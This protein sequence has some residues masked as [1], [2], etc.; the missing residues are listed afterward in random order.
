MKIGWNSLVFVFFIQKRISVKNL[1]RGQ[2]SNTN[3]WFR[4]KSRTKNCYSYDL[5]LRAHRH[6]HILGLQKL[7]TKDFTFITEADTWWLAASRNN[8]LLF[9]L[10]EEVVYC[11]NSTEKDISSVGEIGTSLTWEYQTM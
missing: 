3:K 10:R 9:Q 7:S 8:S 1:G 2:S 11:Q 6:V 5:P 4:G